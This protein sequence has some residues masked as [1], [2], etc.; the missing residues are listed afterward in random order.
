MLT[1]V[2]CIE[3]DVQCRRGGSFDRQTRIQLTIKH[4]RD[5]VL[6]VGVAVT[7][8]QS[9]DE[10]VVDKRPNVDVEWTEELGSCHVRGLR[11][12]CF[13]DRLRSRRLGYILGTGC[14]GYILCTGSLGYTI[15]TG[16]LGYT[17]GSGRY[18]A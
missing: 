9:T 15:G 1:E 11:S 2:A 12:S 5:I 16:S 7:E 8:C 13:G 17:V 6:G 3:S 4:E 18:S 10:V 14:L